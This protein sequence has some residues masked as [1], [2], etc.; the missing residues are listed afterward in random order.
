MSQKDDKLE[1]A[2]AAAADTAQKA[3]AAAVEIGGKVG[4][5]ASD[6]FERIKRTVHEVTDDDGPSEADKLIKNFVDANAAL[7]AAT[8]SGM[9][10]DAY[11]AVLARYG[12]AFDAL[13]THA[14]KFSG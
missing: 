2:R 1:A 9:S 5:M 12:V 6:L 13:K 8:A 3:A 11:Q 4:V 10:G 14:A 7:S